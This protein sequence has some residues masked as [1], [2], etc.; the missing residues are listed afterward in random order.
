MFCKH[1]GREI[2]DSYRYCIYCGNKVVAE[3]VPNQPSFAVNTYSSNV[4]TK[5]RKKVPTAVWVLLVLIIA[6]ISILLILVLPSLNKANNQSN[7]DSVIVWNGKS[8]AEFADELIVSTDLELSSYKIQYDTGWVRVIDYYHLD[9]VVYRVEETWYGNVNGWNQQN[10]DWQIEEL[11]SWAD[12]YEIYDFFEYRIEQ[13]GD[14][15]RAYYTVKDMNL[16]E[17]SEDFINGWL[18]PRKRGAG[19]ISMEMTES[20]LLKDG[21]KKQ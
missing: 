5:P 2:S 12:P 16:R 21:Y 1:C 9:D 6:C 13:D 15:L 14:D 7:Q 11:H 19:L 10:I 20:T 18:F 4:Y 8:A 17:H 3:V